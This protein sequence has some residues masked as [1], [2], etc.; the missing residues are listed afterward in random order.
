M[1]SLSPEIRQKIDRAK[2][3]LVREA[4]KLLADARVKPRDFGHSQ[5]RNLTAVATETESPAVVM[6]F[7]R[8]QMGRADQRSGWAQDVGGKRLGQRFIDA[9]DGKDGAVQKALSEIEQVKGDKLAEQLARMELIRYFLGFATR[10]LKYL[11][12][13]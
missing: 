8:Y 12:L 11:E 2:E 9:L 1:S 7:I 13:S 4:E 3:D 5:L 10:Y 6:N